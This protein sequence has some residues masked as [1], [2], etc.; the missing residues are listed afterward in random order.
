M[1]MEVKKGSTTATAGGGITAGMHLIVMGV[2]QQMSRSDLAGGGITAGMHLI[3]MG[4]NQQMS[5]S[6]LAGGGGIA[7]QKA[8]GRM[9][10]S[11]MDTE[12][13]NGL[14]RRIEAKGEY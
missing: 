13:Q 11:V 8:V 1:R 14:G 2:N 12:G 9:R 7:G 3:V 6:D 4:V 10:M 5:R